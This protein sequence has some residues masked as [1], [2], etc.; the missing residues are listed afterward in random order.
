MDVRSHGPDI[1]AP[2]IDPV[3]KKLAVRSVRARNDGGTRTAVKVRHFEPVYTDEPDS[4]GGT[5]TAPNP[6][7]M[8]LVALVGCDGVIINGVA[9]AM[10]FQVR[11]RRFPMLSPD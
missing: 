11:G 5:N 4:L 8:V 6:L 10:A 2:S 9:K 3:T 1:L 7:E